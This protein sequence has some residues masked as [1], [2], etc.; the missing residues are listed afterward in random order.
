MSSSCPAL[1]CTIPPYAR[2]RFSGC[3]GDNTKDILHAK[4]VVHPDIADAMSIMANKKQL[5][6]LTDGN[7]GQHDNS[8]VETPLETQEYTEDDE[9]DA[10]DAEDDDCSDPEAFSPFALAHSSS[11][12]S[13][14]VGFQDEADRDPPMAPNLLTMD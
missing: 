14:L 12:A 6:G 9:S 10:E 8:T 3:T 11:G 1:D 2:F 5:G 13:R 7:D 4:T